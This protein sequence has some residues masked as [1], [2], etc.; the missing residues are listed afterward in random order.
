MTTNNS[1]YPL[2]DSQLGNI[3]KLIMKPFHFESEDN[4]R[5]HGLNCLHFW[6][7]DRD[8]NT[9]LLRVNHFP[10]YLCLELPKYTEDTND[11]IP[12]DSEIS[13]NI[14]NYFNWCL[15]KK[16]LDKADSFNFLRKNDIYYFS[17]D[18]KPYLYL[19][20]PTKAA[21]D[22]IMYMCE[23]TRN[24][25]KIGMIKM[26]AQERKVDSLRRLMS[27]RNCLY[28]QWFEIEA[29]SVPIDHE[30][31]ASVPTIRE[32][33]VDWKK[34][35]PID[36]AITATW[37][38]DP[39]ILAWDIETYSDNHRSMPSAYNI[40]HCIYLISVIFQVINRPETKK[41]YCIIYGECNE[42]E[43]TE[44]IKATS[45][46]DLMLKY[47]E[48]VKQLD[49]DIISDYNG[50]SYDYDYLITKF[51]INGCKIPSLGRLIN[52]GRDTTIYEKSWA[53]SGNGTNNISFIVA[54]GRIPIDMLPNI[55]RLFKLR[56]YNLNFVSNYF[57]GKGKHDI[58][59]KRMFEIYEVSMR[60]Q[61][62][63]TRF[64][65][66]VDEMTKV[67]EY[68]MQDSELVLG[69]FNKIKIWYY[70]TE[71]SSVAGVPILDLFTRGEQVRWYSSIS[72]Q[73]Y[74]QGYVLSSAHS[75][76]YYYSGGFVGTPIVGIHEYVFTFDFASLYP[77]IMQAYNLCYTTFIPKELWSTVRPED[78]NIIKF[79]QEEPADYNSNSREVNGDD[80]EEDENK[81][82]GD[83]DEKI[84]G[85]DKTK[86][87]RYYEFR[88]IKAHIRRGIMPYLEET[89]V[90]DRN[91]V[92]KELKKVEKELEKA[93]ER[94]KENSELEKE[95]KDLELQTVIL[96]NKQKAIKVF[97]NSGYGFTGAKN[98]FLPGL[99][100][101]M[102]VCALGR[103][104]INAANDFFMDN[105]Q[106]Y[107]PKIV[108]NDTDSSMVS[109]N[110]KATDDF[111][112]IGDEMAEAISGR[113]EKI[114]ADGTV[115]PGITGL[116]REPLKMEFENCCRILCLKKK[117]YAKL[118][119][120][121]KTGEFAIDTKGKLEIMAKG[122]LTA[123]KG[124]SK[125]SMDIYSQGLEKII[126]L[127]PITNVLRSLLSHMLKLTRDELVPREKLTMVQALG[128]DYKK[129]NYFMNLF[130]SHLSRSG[131]PVKPGDRIEYIVVRIPEEDANIGLKGKNKKSIYVG[132]KCR[133]IT[134]WEADPNR[135]EIDYL[136]YMEKGIKDPYDFLFKTG[137]NYLVSDPRLAEVGYKPQFSRC[138]FVHFSSPIKM[139][140]AIV[141]DY[142]ELSEE[143]FVK[144]AGFI[145]VPGEKRI[146]SVSRLIETF[147]DNICNF[148]DPFIKEI[149]NSKIIKVEEELERI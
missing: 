86:V 20:F 137:Y 132:N 84:I 85:D 126:T 38:V 106:K 119:R 104:L 45:E 72:N 59:A 134:L 124:K 12:W 136:Y 140:M 60:K 78:C 125:F 17:L 71:L 9:Y 143:D 79:S 34:L 100:I 117:M 51:K 29:R 141:K 39:S 28:S 75:Y 69:L 26:I 122:I 7:K 91:K 111:K 15:D 50:T 32:Y 33:F 74:K 107:G 44:I 31:R 123:K 94:E 144:N 98:G 16:G 115:I 63:G 89:C 90:A 142:V 54:E 2:D 146:S 62:D 36:P 53:S 103:Q 105:Y 83:R 110:L 41:K 112:K 93:L 43:G 80:D 81:Q 35:N 3:E 40:A 135:E 133:E 130:Q 67:V 145:I 147:I 114:L 88:F 6:T 77:S 129:D 149:E 87:I 22:A 66:A 99:P 18:Q 23:K 13:R 92:K 96:D 24:V 8:S 5:N 73:C 118:V 27:I 148:L 139:I 25:G 127:E 102:A 113:P 19:F 11:Y 64:P 131:N 70:L 4:F 65:E 95:S 82:E 108:Y 121:L 37:M 21:R 46:L 57:L 97:A 56:M 55:K 30:D 14:F 68:C 48:L 47:M 101:A 138:H 52:T 49:P 1:M 116:F 76:D 128:S 58:T 42:V 109:L 120:D 10:H 61:E